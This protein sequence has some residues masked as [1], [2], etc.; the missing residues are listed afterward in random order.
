[1]Y[2]ITYSAGVVSTFGGKYNLYFDFKPEVRGS[3]FFRKAF[4][5]HKIPT[6]LTL[7]SI[8]R[9]CKLSGDKASVNGMIS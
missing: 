8:K 5:P 7:S 3:I 4:N 2:G 1:M 9:H 6:R